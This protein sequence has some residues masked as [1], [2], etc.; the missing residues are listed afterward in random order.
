MTLVK[1]ALAAGAVSALPSPSLNYC[2][3]SSLNSSARPVC[4][5][6][7]ADAACAVVGLTAAPNGGCPGGYYY[8]TATTT[9]TCPANTT[10]I[11]P[12]C[13]CT[14]PYVPDSTRTSCVLEQYTLSLKI[15]PGKIEPSKSATVIATVKDVQGQ[16]KS[17]VA[18]SINVD[19]EAG[20]GGHDHHD[21]QRPKGSL[22]GGGSTGADGTVSFT[23]IAPEVSGTH[24]FTANCVNPACTNNPVKENIDVKVD[25]LEP[26]PDSPFYRSIT[27]NA[28]TNH[29]NTHYLK[30]GASANLVAIAKAYYEATYLLKDGWIPNV[31]LNDASLEWGGVLDCFLT[32]AN[33]TPWGAS[34]EEHRRGSVIDIRARVPATNNKNPDTLLYEKEYRKSARDAGVDLGNPH[35]TGNG[36]HYHL[37]LFGVEE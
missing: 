24:T 9:Y 12:P 13:I 23:F 16:P 25:G 37:R 1:P 2:L 30:P 14:D 17:G 21:A 26:I 11:N 28:D 31:M 35:S 36:R 34:H 3:W 22:S 18:V 33:S 20:T 6:V 15:V 10:R 19:V 5:F 8:W 29:S 32:C 27:P 7:T 4:E